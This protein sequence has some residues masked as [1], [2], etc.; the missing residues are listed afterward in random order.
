[1]GDDI[2][3]IKTTAEDLAI[4]RAE[5]HFADPSALN[6]QFLQ[7]T[8]NSSEFDGLSAGT[9]FSTASVKGLLP[10]SS[11]SSSSFAGL[12]PAF[13]GAGLLSAVAAADMGG[14]SSAMGMTAQVASAAPVTFGKSNIGES[15]VLAGLG[16]KALAD[17]A[18]LPNIYSS[19]KPVANIDGPEVPVSAEF[20]QLMAMLE[21]GGAGVNPED[22]LM[23]LIAGIG[24]KPSAENLQA[25]IDAVVEQIGLLNNTFDPIF[26]GL[27]G[28]VQNQVASQNDMA[29]T[30]L[31]LS[32]LDDAGV[33]STTLSDLLGSL[34]VGSNPQLGS[35]LN[36]DS[37]FDGIASLVGSLPEV[38]L[39]PITT[40]VTD[41]VGGVVDGITD[42][43]NPITDPIIDPI[44]DVIT[45]ITDPITDVITDITNPIIDPITDVITDIT[46]P[47]I[48]PITDVITDITNP[49]TDPIIDPITDVITDI[50]NPITDPIIDPITDVITDITNPVVE[51]IDP[52][53][54]PVTDLIDPV[55]DPILDLIPDVGLLSGLSSSSSSD[56]D[57]GLLG[58]LSSGISSTAGSEGGVLDGLFGPQDQTK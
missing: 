16:N 40:P 6:M 54:D 17:S 48:D 32:I 45:D 10:S 21:G 3:N 7:S 13:S 46:N 5:Q 9:G 27:S 18:V 11:S 20:T 8:L 12:S 22:A 49:I 34:D 28:E 1:M 14:F 42:I 33:V 15:A 52:I 25:A 55:I 2:E 35:L 51:V 30:D 23:S 56:S 37:T 38:D 47:I 57:G 31:G 58:S 24:S 44:T 39:T 50:T 4:E 41:I 29:G 53:L 36:L 19:L 43:T 26:D